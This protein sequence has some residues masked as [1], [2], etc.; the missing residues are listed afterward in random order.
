MCKASLKPEGS[1]IAQLAL[2]LELDANEQVISLGSVEKECSPGKATDLEIAYLLPDSLSEGKLVCTRTCFFSFGSPLEMKIRRP[3]I[4]TGIKSL[5]MDLL[6]DAKLLITADNLSSKKRYQGELKKIEG[7][8]AIISLNPKVLAKGQ[9][10]V[11][12]SIVDKDGKVLGK[13][14]SVYEIMAD[15][16]E[17]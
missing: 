9:G 1:G 13:A 7:H 16:F 15:P 3:V 8:L 2:K 10:R 6:S 5:D 12:I 17:E 14:T 11:S 4:S